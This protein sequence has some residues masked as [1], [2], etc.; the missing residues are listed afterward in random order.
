MGIIE[1]FAEAGA[2]V[3]NSGCGPCMGA[4]QGIPCD[5]ETVLSSSNRNFQGRMGN[6][7]AEIYLASPA[8][9]A[10]GA[11]AGQITDPREFL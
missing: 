5:G 2:L 7:N 10:A 11:V 9:V 8:T 4:H 3:M 6:R 1:T